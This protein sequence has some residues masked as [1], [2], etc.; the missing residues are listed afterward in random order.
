MLQTRGSTCDEAQGG[1]PDG[2]NYQSLLAEDRRKIR[3]K[4]KGQ[5]LEC[6][7]SFRP[8]TARGFPFSWLE[9]SSKPGPK[10]GNGAESFQLAP[11]LPV[12]RSG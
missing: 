3:L 9:L 12:A 4:P 8:R 2:R 10:E 7:E 5:T 11:R 1:W 6:E